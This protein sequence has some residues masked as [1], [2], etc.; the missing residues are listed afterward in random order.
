M[1]K[2]LQKKERKENQSR[3]L[4]IARR[5]KEVKNQTIRANPMILFI[6]ILEKLLYL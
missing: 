3:K 4:K 1:K 6:E 2:S 5:K